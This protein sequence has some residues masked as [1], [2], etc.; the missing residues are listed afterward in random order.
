MIA[1]NHINGNEILNANTQF[2][3]GVISV[4]KTDSTLLDT[5]GNF[6]TSVKLRFFIFQQKRPTDL[7][8][9]RDT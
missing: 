7:L 3:I 4:E 9:A 2:S 5:P 8:Y 1:A 6:S